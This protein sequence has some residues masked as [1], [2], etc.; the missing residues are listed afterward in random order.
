VNHFQTLQ[1][2][3]EKRVQHSTAIES[4][5]AFMYIT[6]FSFQIDVTEIAAFIERLIQACAEEL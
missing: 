1:G 2:E 6:S 5:M 4:V 3:S